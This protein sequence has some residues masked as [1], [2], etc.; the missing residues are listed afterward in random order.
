MLSVAYAECRYVECRY[1]ECRG[2][3]NTSLS[4]KVF[5]LFWT[6]SIKLFYRFLPPIA[7]GGG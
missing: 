1:P 2:A 7:N 6:D 5:L 4:T 3:Y